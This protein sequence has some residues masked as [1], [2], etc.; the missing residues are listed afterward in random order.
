MEKCLL[1]WKKKCKKTL[2][3][4]RKYEDVSRNYRFMAN[5]IKSLP[6]ST[7]H[8]ESRHVPPLG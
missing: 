4:Q 6:V 8:I 3:T 7:H 5:K 2:D 1:T